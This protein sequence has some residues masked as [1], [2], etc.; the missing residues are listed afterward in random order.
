MMKIEYLA[1]LFDGEGCINIRKVPLDNAEGFSYSLRV[2]FCMTHEPI[3]RAIAEQVGSAFCPL[4]VRNNPSASRW[5]VAYQTQ[6][7]SEKGAQLL[8]DMMPFLIVKREEAILAIK[9]QDHI[10]RY[11]NSAKRWTI[12]E[13]VSYMDYREGLRLQIKSLKQT[14]GVP[15][16]M[17]ANSEKVLC[18]ASNGADGQPRAKQ[19]QFK[20][21]GGK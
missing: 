18:P 13:R 20:I 6:L 17:M 7:C 9:L 15:D 3:I 19:A 5:K 10:T 21:V 14:V 1:G 2:I 11:R 16:G 8:R 12:E 4:R